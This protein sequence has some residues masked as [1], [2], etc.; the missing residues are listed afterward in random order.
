MNDNSNNKLLFRMSIF[1]VLVWMGSAVV[2]FFSFDNWTDRGTFGDLFGAINA[3][4]SGL[5]FAALIYTILL[6]RKEINQNKEEIVLN[7]KELS[8]SVKAQQATSKALI[9]QAEQTHLTAKINAMNSL[10]SY[11]NS[12]IENPKSSDQI[13]ELAKQK[14]KAIV[15]QID[16]LI[17]GLSE[18]E[19]D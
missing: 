1:V 15:I 6:Q 12:Q 14:R 17:D 18:S 11:Y 7:R 4:F 2:I 8:K 13:V 3:L 16:N 9:S 19:V 5:A 10:M